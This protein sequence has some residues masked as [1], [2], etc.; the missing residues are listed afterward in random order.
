MA[1]AWESC[2]KI[3][4][5]AAPG[6]TLLYYDTRCQRMYLEGSSIMT[7]AGTVEQGKWAD[8]VYEDE[9]TIT[10]EGY[11][12]I[13]IE[14]QNNGAVFVVAQHDADFV[15]LVYQYMMDISD[16]VEGSTWETQPDNPIKAG[17]I[18]LKNASNDL[19]EDN[20]YSII[21]PGAKISLTLRVGNYQFYD[22]GV[23]YIENSPFKMPANSFQFSGRNKL[24]FFLS[25]Q[26]F[27]ENYK[28][29]GTFTEIFTSILTS[30]GLRPN[31][32]LIED[33]QLSVTLNFDP[34][35]TLLSGVETLLRISDWYIDD[36]PDGTII[37]GSSSFIRAHVASVGIYSFN[38]GKDVF[39]HTIDRSISNVYSRVAVRRR[40]NFAKIMYAAVDYYEGW[41]VANHRTF[42]LDVPD[43]ASDELM[44]ELLT[45]K[46]EQLQYTG[47]VETF[48]STI[49][50]WL[51]TGDI[52]LLAD[53]PRYPG[54]ITSLIHSMGEKGFTT[55]ITVTSGGVITDPESEN[56]AAT[57]VGRMGGA[58]RQRRILDYINSGNYSESAAASDIEAVT[59]GA[60]VAGGYEGTEQE[61]Y[62]NLAL[63]ADG[64]VIPA[65]GTQGQV[66][67][68][69]SSND[70]ETQWT[71]E[72]RNLQSIS[73]ANGATI[74]NNA[75]QQILEIANTDGTTLQLGTE[76]WF[77]AKAN[78]AMSSG[79]IAELA[80]SQGYHALVKK[81]TVAGI[82]ANPGNFMGVVTQDVNTNAWVKCTWFGYVRDL[83]TSTY[84]L[85]DILY[86]DAT[87]G[88]FTNIAPPTG[89]KLRIGVVTRV[90]AEDG[91]IL[92]RPHFI[93]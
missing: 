81:A 5:S 47:I 40:G 74:T 33:L 57:Y 32:Y 16:M 84:A 39:T 75:D 93:E 1:L 66:L 31:D 76:S 70:Y 79:D 78:E 50:P 2:T 77:L 44:Q 73:F 19:F 52:A 22:I 71:N 37:I 69:S 18:T 24:G 88:G 89:L 34:S 58:N 46:A 85:G 6:T 68:K 59:Y 53:V 87:T 3:S 67:E 54:I 62:D 83:N 65:E 86:F 13:D 23:F 17:S 30:A 29:T 48:L 51:Q 61:L 21:S 14:H 91:M 7:T 12:Y 45:Q 15:L 64:A 35:N 60:A 42:Y 26:T 9:L 92:V 10:E 28:F 25:A 72:L 49:R 43:S 41:N 38:R 20:A 27:D 11:G 8:I 56:P 90:N 80:G 82:T 4:E 63:V 36:K 55:K